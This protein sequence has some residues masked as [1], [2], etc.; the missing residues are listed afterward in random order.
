MVT[1]GMLE[2]AGLRKIATDCG[3]DVLE[4]GSEWVAA[5]STQAPLRAW[6]GLS[7]RGP[8]LGLS[9]QSVLAELGSGTA[10]GNGATGLP[11]A[12]WLEFADLGM[13][14]RALLQ[15]WHLSRALPN[16][17]RRPNFDHPCRLNIDQGWKPVSL[18][19]N[20]G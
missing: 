17:A 12:G 4:D 2:R 11:V 20:C 1:L 8:V 5:A 16:C 13:L 3:F 6:L 7:P 15:A 14:D 18:E 19:A 9:M 10:I